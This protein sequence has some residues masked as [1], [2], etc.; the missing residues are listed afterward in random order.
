MKT[1]A[2]FPDIDSSHTIKPDVAVTKFGDGYEHRV[3]VGINAQKMQW[4]LTFDRPRAEAKAILDFL[5]E[6][7]A[8]APFFWT[9]PLE[10]RGV[11]VCR[12]WK[13]HQ[14]RGSMMLSCPFDQIHEYNQAMS[15]IAEIQSLSPSA[16][17]EVFELD[18]TPLGD[19]IIRFHAGTSETNQPIVWQGKTYMA[20]PI[21]AEGFEITTRG[22]L[23]RPTIRIANVD[24]L[25][26][27]AVA[28]FDDLVGA[29]IT[30]KRTFARYLDA[31]NFDSKTNPTADPNQHL[32]DEVWYVEQKKTE[33]RYIIEW[34]LAS[35]MDL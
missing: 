27:A 16:L 6:H 7:N 23:P 24:G 19:E 35:A 13:T 3:A 12:E 26:S 20:L 11:Y 8:V 22:T 17:I 21:E 4:T 18:L 28:E 29:K 14:K 10:E 1:F 31:V 15:V 9:T 30:R 2:W 25:F 32:P 5:R 33:N 34:E